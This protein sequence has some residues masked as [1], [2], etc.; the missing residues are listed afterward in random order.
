MAEMEMSLSL[1]DGST[2]SSLAEQLCQVMRIELEDS[3]EWPSFVCTPCA[4][5]VTVTREFQD[6]I[7]A[8]HNSLYT[9]IMQNRERQRDIEDCE[10]Q[11]SVDHLPDDEEE[12]DAN[13][14]RIESGQMQT[15]ENA[16]KQTATKKSRI[17]NVR[18]RSQEEI[19]ELDYWLCQSG[20]LECP[21]CAQNTNTLSEYIAHSRDVHR[22]NNPTMQCCSYT[23]VGQENILDHA[24]FHLYPERF[25]CRMCDEQ[26]DS[27]VKTDWHMKANHPD[28][29]FQC[30]HC[31]FSVR[32]ASRLRKH[33]AT[34]LPPD[35]KPF[36]C[37]Y[38]EKAFSSSGNKKRHIERIHEVEERYQCHICAKLF[39]STAS[40]W[41]HMKQHRINAEKGATAKRRRYD[42]TEQE[43]EKGLY[44]KCRKCGTG[45][46]NI[47]THWRYT[48]RQEFVPSGDD[49]D[50][51]SC[52]D[53]EKVLAR[54]KMSQHVFTSHTRKAYKCN[55]C[56]M[57][58]QRYNAYQVHMDVHLNRTYKCPL[59]EKVNK[60]AQGRMLHI[61]SHHPEHYAKVS[62]K[63]RFQP[64]ESS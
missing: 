30:P 52:G 34:H 32:D 3:Q 23:H 16:A 59:C 5:L 42:I 22:D 13:G 50:L 44:V 25:R 6:K 18:L 17:K 31:S 10:L 40:H 56:D 43:Y 29:R 7:M 8:T 15:K 58:F 55:I 20:V 53:C 11:S 62:K 33:L 45:H 1:F 39:S 28:N 24:E 21:K 57:E 2:G 47:I 51:I 9:T 54:Y 64:A 49:L 35:E 36:K 37:E 26:F 4:N 63:R 61:R 38:C 60:S 12:E 48:H 27:F 46:L 19:T 41:E 14:Q